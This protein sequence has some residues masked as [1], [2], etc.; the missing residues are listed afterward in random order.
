MYKSTYCHKLRNSFLLDWLVFIL[1]S[2]RNE[3]ISVSPDNNFLSLRMAKG[4]SQDILK[5]N[6]E[7]RKYIYHFRTS[8]RYFT[9]ANNLCNL[10]CPKL[11][12]FLKIYLATQFKVPF[13]FPAFR[14][15]SWRNKFPLHGFNVRFSG[16]CTAE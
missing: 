7:F 14:D 2:C 11:V 10:K 5:T 3:S 6:K 16:E 15:F 9:R 4:K 1:Y 13:S 12:L 8:P